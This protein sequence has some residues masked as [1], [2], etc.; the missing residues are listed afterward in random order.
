MYVVGSIFVM[1]RE[2]RVVSGVHDPGNVRVR[3]VYERKESW[4]T[5]SEGSG[6]IPVWDLQ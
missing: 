4:T 5:W 2:T 1:G 3:S 6:S